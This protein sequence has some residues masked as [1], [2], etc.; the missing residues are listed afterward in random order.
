LSR[1]APPDMPGSPVVLDLRP[2]GSLSA[3]LLRRLDEIMVRDVATF[4]GMIAAL[5]R[6]RERDIDWWVC[7]PVTRNNH[8]STLHARC[9]QLALIRELTDA[10]TKIRVLLDC[11][12]MA[13]VLRDAAWPNVAV[14][15]EGLKKA[16]LR[17]LMAH[18]SGILASVFHC[19]AAAAAAWWTRKPD[20]AQAGT[21]LT[22][23]G[24]FISDQSFDDGRFFDRYYPGLFDGL[25]D[26]ERS[27]CRYIPVFYRMR[28]Y[29]T[30]FRILRRNPIA[31]LF[32]EDQLSFR[33]YLFAFGYW[34]RCRKFR[35]IQ[36]RYAGCEIGPLF[37]LDA[38]AGR[39]A[40]ITVRALLAHRFHLHA[41]ARGMRI[42]TLLDWYEGLDYNHAIAAAINWYG[43]PT[44]IT[45][46][47]SAGSLF[48]LSC[49]PTS[50]EV[51]AGVTPHRMAVVGTGLAEEIRSLCPGLDVI[52]AP[53]MRYRTLAALKRAPEEGGAV[54]LT[55]PLSAPVA[56][57]NI[58]TM[59]AARALMTNPPRHWW[60]KS[61]PILPESEILALLGGA[62]PD[63][64]E[65]VRGDFYAWLARTDLVAGVGSSALMESVALGIPAVCLAAGNVPTE[66][67]IPSWV[68]PLLGRLAYGP[69][70]AALAITEMIGTCIGDRDL[71]ELRENMLGI[72]TEASMRR[73]LEIDQNSA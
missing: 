54:L 9:M 40:S 16:R 72:V 43:S 21:A 29:L 17:R 69:Q 15:L 34:F 38:Q 24:T 46:F 71:A 42:R 4:N 39:F 3:A 30:A 20:P 50:H 25:S 55:L 19:A 60:A 2:G 47:R 45:G 73:L 59:A 37:H 53:G 13:A 56:A 67:P 11:P 57:D 14:T 6:G 49:T 12:V 66:N 44:S 70:E 52:A 10:G 32:Y 36:A 18:T 62:L 63:G 51:S 1:T 8:V 28:H 61:H 68:D 26:Q 7:R 23:V 5:S 31:F 65:F 48:Y 35:G 58:R 33:D 22:A 64:M 41:E 27:R